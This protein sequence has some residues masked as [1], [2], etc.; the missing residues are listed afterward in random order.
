MY[1]HQSNFRCAD[2]SDGDIFYE[3]V[4]AHLIPQLMPFNG[5]NPHSVVVMDNC[6]IHHC[7]EVVTTLR[8]VG[9]LVHF[10]PPYSL[11]FNL[12]EQVF[13]KVKMNLRSAEAGMDT[14]T[15]VLASFAT[16]S[17][18]DCRGWNKRKSQYAI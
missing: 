17:A 7:A 18:D 16:I 9:V 11:D 1:V 3:F 6:S 12:I 2:M 15:A 5:I 13:S 14:E 4:Q 10:L 8:D